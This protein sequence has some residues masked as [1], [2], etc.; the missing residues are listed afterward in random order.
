MQQGEEIRDQLYLSNAAFSSSP[1]NRSIHV[2]SGT[3]TFHLR[4][5]TEVDYQK[6]MDALRCVISY[7]TGNTSDSALQDIHYHATA[8]ER[9]RWHYATLGKLCTHCQFLCWSRSKDERFIG[10]HG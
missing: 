2:D 10:R 3:A 4:A 7:R 9:G 5:L 6:W 1:S 8:H